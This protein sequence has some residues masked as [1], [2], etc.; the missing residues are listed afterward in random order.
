M[1]MDQPFSKRGMRHL[2]VEFGE[3]F[4]DCS[5]KVSYI[6]EGS[7]TGLTRSPITHKN[8]EIK[9]IVMSGEKCSVSAGNVFGD[10]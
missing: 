3:K 8:L 7:L 9:S 6:A 2:L 5:A 1:T 4:D 10:E